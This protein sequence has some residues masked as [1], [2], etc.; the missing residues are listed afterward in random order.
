[1]KHKPLTNGQI[2]AVEE[3]QASLLDDEPKYVD[4]D[5]FKY[6]DVRSALQ[7]LK[8]AI[9]KLEKDLEKTFPQHTETDCN[10]DC[11]YNGFGEALMVLELE[12]DVWFPA[13]KQ[14]NERTK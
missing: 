3:N 10:G 8:Q 2:E 4:V 1:M 5:Y 12:I 13:F 6:A 14:K 7:G 11:Y 9:K